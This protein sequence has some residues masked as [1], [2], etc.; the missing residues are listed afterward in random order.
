MQAKLFP[1]TIDVKRLEGELALFMDYRSWLVGRFGVVNEAVAEAAISTY[2]D[3]T[4][5]PG[6]R[7]IHI[8]VNQEDGTTPCFVIPLAA[9]D[10]LVENDFYRY[11]YASV[12]ASTGQYQTTPITVLV[13]WGEGDRADAALFC[14]DTRIGGKLDSK[15]FVIA[16]RD[17][18]G[19]WRLSRTYLFECAPGSR[20]WDLG[21]APL[22]RDV[23]P[24]ADTLGVSD[25]ALQPLLEVQTALRDGSHPHAFMRGQSVL[26]TAAEFLR[27]MET[28]I[29]S[30]SGDQV[31]A[32]FLDFALTGLQL[33]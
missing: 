25:E 27:F 13:A 6:L 5:D 33:D 9:N 19:A 22:T 1:D 28:E 29:Y 18:F 4:F 23:L 17:G 30:R 2:V 32:A 26:K 15:A 31:F 14:T 8:G 20:A 21:N 7:Q 3:G 10:A 12:E 24:N 11:R 16:C